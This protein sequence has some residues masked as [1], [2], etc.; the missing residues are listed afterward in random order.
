MMIFE[1]YDKD[2]LNK[3]KL[4]FNFDVKL[5]HMDHLDFTISI[6]K[7]VIFIER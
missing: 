5:F 7:A 2:R 4:I 6:E 3:T 1:S